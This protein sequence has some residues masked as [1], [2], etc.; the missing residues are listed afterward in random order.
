VAIIYENLTKWIDLKDYLKKHC[1]INDIVVSYENSVRPFMFYDLK[2]E[3]AKMRKIMSDI[4]KT[5]RSK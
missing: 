4:K 1:K 3:D 5:A 2:Q